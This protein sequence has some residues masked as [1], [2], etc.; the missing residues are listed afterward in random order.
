MTYKKHLTPTPLRQLIVA[1]LFILGL[2]FNPPLAGATDS[3]T[4][5]EYAKPSALASKAL[6]LDVAQIGGRLVAVGEFGHIIYSDNNGQ[7]WAQAKNVPTRATL[8][9][10]FFLDDKVGFAVGHDSVILKTDNGGESWS[11][12]HAERGGE[13]PLFAIYF[14]DAQHG[15]A[16]GAF[17]TVL[18]TD[19]GGESWQPRALI[20]DSFDDFHLNDIFADRQGNI[21]I[22]AEFGTIYKSSDKGQTWQALESGYDG[23]FWGGM[24]LR[25]GGLLIW[26]MRGNVYYSTDAGTS[27]QR[28]ATNSDRSVS[29]GTQLPDGRVVLTGLSGSVLVSTDNGR[30]FAATVRPDRLSFANVSQ[31]GENE[32]LLYGD[33]GVLMH[34]L[35]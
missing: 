9:G 15:L 8:T 6:L 20:K 16:V 17:S 33:P 4:P 18:Q 12:K 3:L 2:L 5:Y 30:N 13:N 29:G 35:E 1:P 10:I 14:T 23:S 31:G 22:P 32:V 27:W 28:A 19:D 34:E 7:S 25:G 24:A 26:G 11:L 21:F